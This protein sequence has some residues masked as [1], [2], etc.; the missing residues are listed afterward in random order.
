MCDKVYEI[1]QKFTYITIIIS[2]KRNNGLYLNAEVLH[3]SI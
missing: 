3:L 1:Q 2:E